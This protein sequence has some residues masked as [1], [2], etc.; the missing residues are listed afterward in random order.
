MGRIPQV[1][2]SFPVDLGCA[3][4]AYS[5]E[6]ARGVARRRGELLSS[7][8]FKDRE[9][10]AE[11]FTEFMEVHAA[12]TCTDPNLNGRTTKSGTEVATRT[13]STG[14]QRRSSP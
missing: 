9:M 14:E 4:K 2:D 11:Q 12:M 1:T 6:E 5:R 10:T 13:P 8:P 7:G 3:P